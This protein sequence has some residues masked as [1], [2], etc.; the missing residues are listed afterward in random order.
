MTTAAKRWNSLHC[1]HHACSGTRVWRV[2]DCYMPH[3]KNGD[4]RL[5]TMLLRTEDPCVSFLSTH[6]TLDRTNSEHHPTSYPP[7]F[8][9]CGYNNALLHEALWSSTYT[10]LERALTKVSNN[11]P[12]EVNVGKSNNCN[13]LCLEAEE[14]KVALVEIL[15]E[16]CTFA[17]AQDHVSRVPL[18]VAKDAS[19]A[20][21]DQGDNQPQ[22]SWHSQIEAVAHSRQ[23]E[24]YR[25]IRASCET[26]R[27]T[28][29]WLQLW[30]QTRLFQIVI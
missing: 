2:W 1:L 19:T 11:T 4:N 20:S 9:L 24:R 21:A 15:I 29:A 18:H 13:P 10:A 23:A 26:R 17:N 6:S 28:S 25:N 16:H 22:H 7:L 30:H 14:G 12:T 5:A 27:R 3:N 8:L